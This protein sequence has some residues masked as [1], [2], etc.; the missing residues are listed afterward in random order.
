MTVE[1]ESNSKKDVNNKRRNGKK[2]NLLDT[3]FPPAWLLFL[4]FILVLGFNFVTGFKLYTMEKEKEAL[5]IL[6]GQFEGYANL[7]KDVEEKTKR[8]MELTQEIVPLE[9]RKENAIAEENKS[10]KILEESRKELNKIKAL[11]REVEEELKANRKTIAELSNDK[12]LLRKEGEKLEAFVAHLKES[13]ARTEQVLLSKKKEL[14]TID[15]KIRAAIIRLEDQNKYLSDVESANSSFDEI[16]SKLSALNE[17]LGR[18]QQGAELALNK[19]EKTINGL[20]EK[21]QK[22]TKELNIFTGNNKQFA[23]SSQSFNT[24]VTKFDADSA[25]FRKELNGF[26]TTNKSMATSFLSLENGVA[27]FGNNNG[28]I[29]TEMNKFSATNKSIAFSSL[30]LS[31]FLAKFDGDSTALNSGVSSFNKEVMSISELQVRFDEI[32]KQHKGVVDDIESQSVVFKKAIQQVSDTPD[33]KEQL[34]VLNNA[35]ITIDDA[36]QKIKQT[37]NMI[38]T[39]FNTKLNG[40]DLSFNSLSQDVS[41]L[42]IKIAKVSEQIN[43]MISMT[44]QNEKKAKTN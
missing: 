13:E 39:E 3:F 18:T 25:L 41:S 37:S 4:M 8:L 29:E 12:Q 38:Q 33:L 9:V 1:S 42:E 34:K 20:E 14:Q 17:K 11:Q 7:I 35:L 40:M 15:E 6:Q 31:G 16:R 5:K 26:V 10:T 28:L 32:N 19:F 43:A 22:I 24:G 30:S 44:Q 2:K 36:T 27:R 21:S 23:T